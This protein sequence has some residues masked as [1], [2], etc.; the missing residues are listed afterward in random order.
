LAISELTH[1][2]GTWTESRYKSFITS[3]LRAGSR[4]WPPKYST[5]ADAKTEKKINEKT[6][7]LA[8]HYKCF[9]CKKD[10][11]AEDVQVDHIKPIVDPKEGFQT[12]DVY[13]ANLFCE[14][15]NMQVLC[16]D[17]H[18]L[19]TNKEKET[20]KKYASK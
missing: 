14:K 3:T 7:R 16:K 8:Q 19:K 1:N 10:W 12:W 17:C 15:D 13:I 6:G 2:S 4:R 20:K 9:K 11:P 5:L 18:V